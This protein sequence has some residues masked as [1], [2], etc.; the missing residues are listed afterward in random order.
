MFRNFQY[1]LETFLN[2]TTLKSFLTKVEVK[3]IKKIVNGNR[4]NN[5]GN[6]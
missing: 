1:K 2:L 5:L 4:E 6:C 3:V